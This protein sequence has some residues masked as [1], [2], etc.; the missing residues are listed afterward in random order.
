MISIALVKSRRIRRMIKPKVV[1]RKKLFSK[2]AKALL[3]TEQLGE[4][5]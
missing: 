4:L 3:K 1:K 5:V 2:L